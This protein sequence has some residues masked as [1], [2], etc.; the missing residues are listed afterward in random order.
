MKEFRIRIAMH[1]Y[2]DDNVTASEIEKA[3]LVEM[4]RNDIPIVIEITELE[5]KEI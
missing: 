5:N 1:K 3:I 4:E 2:D